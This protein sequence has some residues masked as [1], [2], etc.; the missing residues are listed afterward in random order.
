MGKR[1]CIKINYIDAKR[2]GI[3]YRSLENHLAD[4]QKKG[5]FKTV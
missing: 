2:G 1:P 4:A 5:I 3:A